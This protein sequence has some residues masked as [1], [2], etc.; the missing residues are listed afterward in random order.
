MRIGARAR[1]HFSVEFVVAEVER[2][3]DRLE[4]LEI[5]A[6]LLFFAF[7]GDDGTAVQHEAIVRHFVVP[8][9]AS[10]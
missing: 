4:R 8:A 10:D 9:I 6:E 1:T 5:N 2:G 3:I 7:S